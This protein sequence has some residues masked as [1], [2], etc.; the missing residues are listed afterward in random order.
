MFDVETC[1]PNGHAPVM[2][3]AVSSEAWL[4]CHFVNDVGL[5]MAFK[6]FVSVMCRY[7]WCSQSLIDGIDQSP[8][9]KLGLQNLIPLETEPESFCQDK[10]ALKEKIVVGHNVSFDRARI[11]EQYFLEETKL[12]FIDTMSLHIAVSGITSFQRVLKMTMKNG[13]QN[14]SSEKREELLQAGS[15]EWN[16]ISSLNNLEDVHKVR[17]MLNVYWLF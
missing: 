16:D 15:L 8:N 6:R 13:L 1:V 3:S 17:A 5:L 14:L 4:V 7:S 9:D 2:A 10:N 12:R 11:K